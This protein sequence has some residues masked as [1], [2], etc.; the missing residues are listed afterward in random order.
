MREGWLDYVFPGK[1]ELL[2]A[3]LDRLKEAFRLR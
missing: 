1:S 2:R 3:D